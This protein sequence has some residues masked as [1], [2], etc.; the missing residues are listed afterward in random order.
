MNAVSPPGPAFGTNRYAPDCGL[1]PVLSSRN[2][3]R[4]GRLA[5]AAG[6]GSCHGNAHA[7]PGTTGN[8]RLHRLP[9]SPLRSRRQPGRRRAW[10]TSWDADVANWMARAGRGID[11]RGPYDTRTAV[12]WGKSWWG[13]PLAGPCLATDQAHGNGG[14]GHPAKDHGHHGRPT[15]RRLRR[16][17]ASRRRASRRP[18]HRRAGD[19]VGVVRDWSGRRDSNPRSRAPKARALPGYATPR[20]LRLRKRDTSRALRRRVAYSARALSR[21][22]EQAG[23]VCPRRL[24]GQPVAA[25]S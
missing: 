25:K 12:F 11:V 21:P 15:H 2:T 16:R 4:S 19:V 24:S 13:G 22:E 14:H 9:G 10:P 6:G 8:R 5:M 1:R 23:S 18:P 20:R 17:R 7:R 3:H